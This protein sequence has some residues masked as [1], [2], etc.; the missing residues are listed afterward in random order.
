MYLRNF[1]CNVILTTIPHLFGLFFTFDNFFYSSIIISSTL[2]SILWHRKREPNNIL[3]YLDY[4]SASILSFYEIYRAY[5]YIH[6]GLFTIAICSNIYI[7]V[8]NKIIYFLSKEGVIKYSLW[9]SFYHILSSVKTIL[10]A[11]LN[12][13]V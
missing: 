10:L 8:F 2:T 11:F 6:N 5:Y 13:N 1:T 7:L 3:L 4:G 9:H 12:C